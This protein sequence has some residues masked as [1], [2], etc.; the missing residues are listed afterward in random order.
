MTTIDDIA[1]VQILPLVPGPLDWLAYIG[2]LVNAYVYQIEDGCLEN[3]DYQTHSR[4][5]NWIAYVRPD[6]S[7]PG[8]LAR[9]F[10]SKGSG[11][12]FKMPR[13]PV[14][15]DVIEMAG[16]YYTGRGSKRPD[17]RYV[18]VHRAAPDHIV[19]YYLGATAP[20]RTAIMRAEERL[21]VL[22]SEAA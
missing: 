1:P 5:K 20:S 17:R 15:G 16:D 8:G 3:L 19:G 6:R 18:Y 21:R 7:E 11:R 22:S 9:E 12:W 10:F 13:P 14:P 2:E 4:G